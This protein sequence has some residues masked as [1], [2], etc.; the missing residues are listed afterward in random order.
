[1]STVEPLNKDTFGTS[2]F[3]LCRLFQRWFSIECVYTNTFGL[4]FVGRFVLFRSVLYQRFHCIQKFDCMYCLIIVVL[5]RRMFLGSSCAVLL[6][7]LCIIWRDFFCRNSAFQLFTTWVYTTH[8]SFRVFTKWNLW[9]D[10]PLIFIFNMYVACEIYISGVGRCFSTE[11]L[12]F[13]LN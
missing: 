9:R 7:W 11:G 5:F 10:W 3:V 2:C 1:M 4:S 6:E 8:C 12:Q 13:F